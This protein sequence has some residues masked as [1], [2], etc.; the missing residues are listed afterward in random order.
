MREK[1]T[2]R[3]VLGAAVAGAAGFLKPLNIL[4][5]KAAQ[6]ATRVGFAVPD[7]ACDCHVHVFGDPQRYPFAPGRVYTP[8]T[9]SIAELR[10]CLDALHMD[11]VVIVQASVY[12]T[13]N[14]CT[15]DAVRELG[16]RARGVA[17]IDANTPDAAL[18]DMAAAGIRGVRLNLSTAGVSDPSVALQAFT[19]AAERASKR[20]WHIQ[21]N[22]SL[23]LIDAIRSQLQASPVPVV[24]DHFGGAA[25]SAGVQQPGFEA[26][27]ALVKSGTAYVKISGAADSVSKRAPDYPD[28]SPLARAL[29]GANPQRI[30]WGSN[31]P[32]PD[33]ARV[34]G[35]KNTDI[36]PLMQT[37][38]GRVLNLLAEWVPDAAVRRGILVENPARLYGF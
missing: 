2:R 15:V 16:R 23:K 27:V 25:A 28:V 20:K 1:V 8:E 13:D 33:S 36:A 6:P 30:L 24:F 19:T 4:S 37:D 17:V 26:L 34:A 12:G 22:T 14:R 9:A 38:D 21:L 10:A 18:D 35:R 7:G 29:V 32:H 31:W 11:R 5:A 3:A